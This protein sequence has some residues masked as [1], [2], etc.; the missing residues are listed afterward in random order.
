M[1]LAVGLRGPQETV[2]RIVRVNVE[3]GDR[4]DGVVAIW[5]RALPRTCARAWDIERCESTVLGEREAVKHI[6]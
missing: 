6:A 1:C 2:P 5:I 3:S 4:A